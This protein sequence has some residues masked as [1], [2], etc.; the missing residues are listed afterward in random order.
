MPAAV[1]RVI[2]PATIGLVNLQEA[3]RAQV[4]DL[5]SNPEHLKTLP[6]STTIWNELL[7]PD[8]YPDGRIPDTESLFEESQALLFGG[9]DTTGI[10]LMHGTFYV[11]KDMEVYQKLKAEL[12][13]A[14]RVLE[15]APSQVTLE[16]LPYLV[17]DLDQTHS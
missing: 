5:S 8:S 3:I 11:L 4:N 2:S 15:I 16:T 10:T 12:R 17:C 7:R 14:W 9:A 1:S 13:Q 6:H